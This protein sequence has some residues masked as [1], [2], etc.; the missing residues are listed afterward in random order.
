[1]AFKKPSL[2][3]LN[4]RIAADI[5]L[6]S[7]ES[8][9]RRGD[10]YYPFKQALAAAAY[11]AHSHIDYNR[12]QLFDETA[13][14]EHLVRRAADLGI[15][16][17]AASR[18]AGTVSIEA[19]DG[20]QIPAGETIVKSD[21]AYVTTSASTAAEG[22]AIVALRAVNAGA[23]DNLAAGETL[24][25]QRTIDGADTTATV[26]EISGGTDIEDIERLRARLQERRQ[27]PPMGGRPSDYI[28]W[29]KAAHSDVTRAWCFNNENG[30]GT[31]V[32]RFVTDD[33]ET[34]IPTQA[35]ID[36][37]TDYIDAERPAGMKGFS[38]GSLIEKPL[39]ITFSYL[40][41]NTNAVQQQVEAELLDLIASEVEPGKTLPIS[42]IR[43]A[44]SAAAGEQDHAFDLS[45]DITSASHEIIALGIITWPEA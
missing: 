33:L 40:L 26:I 32:V 19:N 37:V 38:V 21:R 16:R 10:I 31:V 13:D 27:N 17:V 12:E 22:A 42:R 3:E 2:A 6:A 30:A 23:I 35:H 34:R 44:I 45:A 36:A 7:G 24:T 43:E 11:S 20:V 9:T 41:P 4:A 15:Y 18:A 29:A 14:P 5:E 28:Q 25:L 1:M 39:D 8:A